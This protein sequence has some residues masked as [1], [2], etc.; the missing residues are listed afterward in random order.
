MN[1]PLLI[2]GL[3]LRHVLSAGG[4][5]VVAAGAASGSQAEIIAGAITTLLS[6]AWSVWQKYHTKAETVAA[7][8]AAK[9]AP[10]EDRRPPN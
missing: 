1:M 2:I 4:G 5:V 7:V 8:D 6:A 9:L 10:V 3:V